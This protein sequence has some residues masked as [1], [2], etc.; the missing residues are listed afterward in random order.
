MRAGVLGWR[1]DP[2]LPDGDD[3]EVRLVALSAPGVLD[4]S[5]GPFSVEGSIGEPNARFGDD[6]LINGGFERGLQAWDLVDGDPTTPEEQDGVRAQAG[7]RFFHGGVDGA[8]DCRV[9]QD[10]DLLAE[11]FAAAELDAGAVLD[12]SSFLRNWFGAGA[13]DDQVW[14]GVVHLA[15]DG[16]PLSEVRTMIGGDDEWLRRTA[17]GLLPRGTRSLRVYLEGRHRRGADNDSMADD[18]HVGLDLP[19]YEQVRI[20]KQP[21]LQDY[22]QDAMTLLWETNTNLATH[23]VEWGLEDPESNTTTRLTTTEVDTGHFVHQATLRPLA[24]ETA[25]V[26]R[27]RSGDAVSPLYTFRTAPEGDT[28]FRVAWTSDNQ[29]GAAVFTQLIAGLARRTPDLMISAGDVVQNGHSMN[30]WH[31]QWFVPL[32]ESSFAQTTPILFARG[33]HDAEHFHSYAYSALPA[34]GSWYAF[35]YGNTYFVVLNTEGG[36]TGF[37]G[38]ED[39]TAFLRRALD[40]RDA[41]EAAFRVVVFHK[42]PFSNLWDSPG[43]SGEQ[44]VRQAWVPLMVDGG[45]DLVVC[46]HAH[47]YERGALDGI[48]YLVVG[49][50]GGHLDHVVMDNYDFIGIIESVHHYAV[51]D[52]DAAVMTWEVYDEDEALVDTFDLVSRT[53]DADGG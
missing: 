15:A 38:A 4:L 23:A 47:G 14:M 49:G 35:L 19:A 1:V 9:E 43:Y 2:Y 12:A 44:W 5:D 53:W 27:V 26:Y 37:H 21:M 29:N 22:R 28:P 20:L 24:A 48:T 52:V 42:P 17:T 7:D 13:F 46:G 33:N 10:I 34:Q 51:M 18:L 11:G 16:E 25:Y 45:V 36:A 30:E 39:Q 3:Y 6:L 8:G 40:T 41:Q 32:E 50:A 31:H